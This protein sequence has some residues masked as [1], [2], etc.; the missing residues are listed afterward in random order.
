MHAPT[1]NRIAT[2]TR[3]YRTGAL[4]LTN[5]LLL[6]LII[7][8][9]MWSAREIHQALKPLPMATLQQVY[10]GFSPSD[11]RQLLDE[12]AE[13]WR[14]EPWV[15]FTER[16]HAGRFVNISKDGFRFTQRRDLSLRSDGI[17]IYFFGGST[18]FGYGVDDASTVAAHL[19]KR[20]DARYPG[21]RINVFNFAR[22]YYY[23]TQEVVLLETLLRDGHVPDVVIFLDGLNEGQRAPYYTKDM[24]TLFDAYNYRQRSLLSAYAQKSSTM[25]VVNKLLGRRESGV[26][27]Q[28][29]AP[30]RI[31]D[32]YR[33][34]QDMIRLLAGQFGFKTYFF[35]QPVAGYKNGFAKHAFMPDGWPPG[36]GEQLQTRMS[37][38]E[39]L[40]N[41]RDA[42]SLAAILEHQTTQPFVDEMHYTGA[43]C[44]SIAEGIV[45]KIS[46]PEPRAR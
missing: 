29:P 6:V 11:I 45:Q 31:A 23:S 36:A 15:G 18:G 37:L 24:A 8:G 2:W 17:N 5:T 12:S 13:T 30:R 1:Q 28:L 41:D 43:V 40:S 44:D 26:L 4:I 38:L 39:N 7:N 46:P 14:Y 21:R 25:L 33:V 27:S 19:Q 42:F 20:L 22:G 9:A 3:R 10:P 16:A 35:I 32:V 34:N